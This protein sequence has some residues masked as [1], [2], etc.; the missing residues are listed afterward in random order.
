MGTLTSILTRVDLCEL[1]ILEQSNII[2]FKDTAIKMREIYTL[3]ER[4]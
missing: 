2:F 1:R 3:W 4:D